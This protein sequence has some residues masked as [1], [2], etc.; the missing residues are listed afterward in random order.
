MSYV[1]Y[2]ISTDFVERVKVKMK[3]PAVKDK[4]KAL[5]DGVTKRDLQDRAKVKRLVAHAAAVLNERLTPQH[6]DNIVD[7]VLAQKID[8]KN[9]FHLLKLWS[10]FR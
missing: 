8:P 3:S 1:K 9:T 5:L 4:I 7:F 10:M 6:A 2:G